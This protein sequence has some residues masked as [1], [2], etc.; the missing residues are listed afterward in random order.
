[1]PSTTFQRIQEVMTK[2]EDRL[3][4]TAQY[5]TS[6]F[7]LVQ[8]QHFQKDPDAVGVDLLE[9]HCR[10]VALENASRAFDDD[11]KGTAL[12]AVFASS[13]QT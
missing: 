10:K 11:Q 13:N 5:V 6:Q 7:L 8:Q 9:L 12:G 3:P 2:R 4:L 1:M